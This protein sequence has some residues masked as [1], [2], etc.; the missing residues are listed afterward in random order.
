MLRA[1]KLNPDGLSGSLIPRIAHLIYTS[2]FFYF[3]Q[4]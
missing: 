1:A 4:P 2:P 3:S